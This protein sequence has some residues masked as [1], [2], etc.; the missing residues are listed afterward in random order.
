LETEIDYAKVAPAAVSG[1]HEL[2]IELVS[3]NRTRRRKAFS[4]SRTSPLRALCVVR[5][6]VQ[7]RR[8]R[9][10][11]YCA[12]QLDPERVA[13]VTGL[14]A[15]AVSSPRLLK[16]NGIRIHTQ[17][18][19]RVSLVLVAISDLVLASH[20]QRRLGRAVGCLPHGCFCSIE[21]LLWCPA[22]GRS[23]GGLDRSTPPRS[24]FVD[25]ILE[26]PILLALWH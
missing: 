3:V 5:R 19:E 16:P 24:L 9:L 4:E 26:Y 15:T 18:N 2:L 13:A 7:R 14:S 20:H 10:G 21:A 17:S 12:A 23:P 8:H 22:G 25:S 1:S 11:A 6:C